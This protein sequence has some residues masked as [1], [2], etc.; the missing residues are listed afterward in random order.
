MKALSQQAHQ[1][2]TRSN[3]HGQALGV[4]NT[5]VYPVLRL[6]STQVNILHIRDT[7]HKHKTTIKNS[8]HCDIYI[9]LHANMWYISV[10]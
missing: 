4:K 10:Q 7:L 6:R 5:Q 3:S 8:R 1:F 2:L 9:C